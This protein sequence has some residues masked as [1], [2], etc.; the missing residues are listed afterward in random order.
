MKL[1]YNF[2]NF[3]K[4]NFD[5]FIVSDGKF[6]KTGNFES[7]KNLYPSIEIIDFGGRLILPGFNDS[8]IHIWKVGNL[9]TYMLDLSEAKNYSDIKNNILEFDKKNNPSWIIARGFNEQNL[10]EKEIPN[11][12]FLDSIKIDK[13]VTLIRN[14]A[15]IITNNSLALKLSNVNENTKIPFGGEI[16]R[17]E[18]NILNGI[19]S[20]TAIGLVQNKFPKY[21]PHEYEKMILRAQDEMLKFG[22]TSATDPAVH[23]EL[24]EVYKKMEREGK[25]KIRINAI[26]IRIPDGKN[27]E[28][29]IPGIYETEFLRVN[30]IKYFSDGGL[31][32]MTAAVSFNY[33]NS[34]SHGVLRLNKERFL[35]STKEAM[36]KGFKIATHAIGDRAINMVIDVY[37]ELQKISP[38]KNRIEHL[39]IVD[40]NILARLKNVPTQ[41]STQPIFLKELGHNFL[42]YVPED[43]SKKIYPFKKLFDLGFEVSFSSDAPVVKNYS[44]L[45]GISSAVNRKIN[46]EEN[47]TVLDGIKAFTKNGALLDSVDNKGEIEENY[48]ADFIVLD[49]FNDS[50]KVEDLEKIKIIEV[51]VAGK[52]VL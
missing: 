28:N 1:F 46:P 35:R 31:S 5:A 49:Y 22:I 40:E 29:P 23:P 21:T 47:C 42:K 8:H 6:L 50:L 19:L 39:G 41:I 34:K 45:V 30:T 15:H 12:K 25:L 17:N 51:F 4:N 16:R 2:K 36:Q 43:E 26:P 7:L 18:K 37:E 9:L 13:P 24:L 11:L 44:P 48:L 10:D 38:I 27:Y 33:K 32:G 3:P 20:E 52:K 14:C